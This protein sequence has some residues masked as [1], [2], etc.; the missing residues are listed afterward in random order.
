MKLFVGV[1][2]VF[3]IAAIGVAQW[4][5]FIKAPCAAFLIALLTLFNGVITDGGLSVAPG[6]YR[7]DESAYF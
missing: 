4:C 2:D 3:F 5:V 7:S 1:F 6:C